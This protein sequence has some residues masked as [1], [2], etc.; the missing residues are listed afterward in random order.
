MP[1]AASFA[2]GLGVITLEI[3]SNY[4]RGLGMSITSAVSWIFTFFIVQFSPYILNQFAG[5]FLFGIFAFCSFLTLIFVKTSIP[6][7]K[8]KSLEE[9]ERELTN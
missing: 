1:F 3:F 6:E 8:G 5:S 4:F 2:L 7:T 9:I